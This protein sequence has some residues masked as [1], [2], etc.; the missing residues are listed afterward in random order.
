MV[1]AYADFLS[2]RE[3]KTNPVDFIITKPFALD[4][5]ANALERAHEINKA[6]RKK[7][8]PSLPLPGPPP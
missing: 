8:G 3:K 2:P 7:T 1:T 6:N 5:I 4:T